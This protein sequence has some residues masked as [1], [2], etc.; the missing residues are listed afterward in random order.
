LAFIHF[1]KRIVREPFS[2][3]KSKK[4]QDRLENIPPACWQLKNVFRFR[5]ILAKYNKQQRTQKNLRRRYME[6]IDYGGS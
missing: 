4:L 3:A 2:Q 6:Q 1:R 5:H